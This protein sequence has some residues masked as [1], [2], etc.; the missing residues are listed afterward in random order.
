LLHRRV[1]IAVSSYKLLLITLAK[2][3]CTS[4][5][6]VL[7]LYCSWLPWKTRLRSNRIMCQVGL[8]HSRNCWW[9]STELANAG[10]P[11]F[12]GND[13]DDQLKRIFK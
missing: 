7:Q 9:L 12:P 10:R 8:S 4:H 3:R 5:V 13:V 11:L 6:K 1:Y 2:N